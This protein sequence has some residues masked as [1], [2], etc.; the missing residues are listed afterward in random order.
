VHDRPVVLVQGFGCHPAALAPLA[1]RIQSDLGRRTLCLASG[2]GFR[3]IRDTAM[4]LLDATEQAA[5]ESAFARVDVV[6]HSMGGLVATYLLKCL[7]HGRRIR[8]VVTLGTPFGGIGAARLASVL[9]PLAGSLG[10][11]APGSSLLRLL[12]SL[13]V[14]AGSALV[15][16]TGSRDRI[17]TEA[18]ARLCDAPGHHRMDAG[19]CD[20]L[21]LLWGRRGFA[22][23]TLALSQPGIELPSRARP[24]K[25][26]A[27]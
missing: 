20:H 26:S 17:V 16:I 25:A 12:A 18:A 11:I 10:Q 23:V 21:Q 7:D 1:Q 24:A 19:P 15:A 22:S 2:F 3:D 4:R 27:A 6:A 5:N 13:P 8:R 14:P 9:G